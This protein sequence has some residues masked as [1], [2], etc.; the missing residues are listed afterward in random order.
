MTTEVAWSFKRGHYLASTGVYQSYAVLF[1]DQLL[2]D[3][4]TY[5]D[6]NRGYVDVVRGPRKHRL[7]GTVKFRPVFS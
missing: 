3:E 7:F 2:E 5:V 6:L 4:I 1:N